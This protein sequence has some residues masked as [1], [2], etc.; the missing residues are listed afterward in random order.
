MS[1]FILTDKVLEEEINDL[2][3]NGMPEGLYLN[4]NSLDEMFRLDLGMVAIYTGVP[5]YGKSEFIDFVN[6]RLNRLYGLKVLY[7][8]PEN[9]PVKL[10]LSK[11][12]SKITHKKFAD[13][14]IEEIN[15]AM[16]IIKNNFFFIN[17]ENSMSIDDILTTA[18]Y[19]ISNLGIKI[20]TIDPYNRI[21]WQRPNNL[22]ETEYVGVVMDKLSRFAKKHNILVQLV[23]HPK[24]MQTVN[25]EVQIPNLY[26]LNGSANFANMADYVIIV[27]RDFLN[28]YTTIKVDK[29]KFKN[30]GRIGETYIRY[31]YSDGNYQEIEIDG[32]DNE[33]YKVAKNIADKIL[34]KREEIKAKEI[35]S[36][37]VLDVDISYFN[38]CFEMEGKT[39][40]L[41][42][43]LTDPDNEYYNA[44]WFKVEEIR[45]A[46]SK[47]DIRELKNKSNLPCVTISCVT[48]KDKTDIK[49]VNNLIAID[50]D[51]QD[52]EREMIDI[53]EQLKML[54]YVA[55][56]AKS[57]SG[58]GLFCII[59]ILDAFSIKDYFNA[60]KKEF[61]EM[62][63][64]IDKN[65]SNVNRL[66]FYSFDEN[67]YINPNAEIYTKKI[68]RQI[69]ITKTFEGIKGKNKAE[70]TIIKIINILQKNKDEIKQNYKLDITYDY[71][72]WFRIGA[73]IANTFGENGYKYFNAISELSVK[74]NKYECRYKYTE[75]LC[76]PASEIQFGTLVKL[77]TD[78]F[79]FE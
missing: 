9:M 19:A 30:Y 38:N 79:R 75:L 55:Y 12:I 41:Y 46:E 67:Y 54:K 16:E 43:Y 60:I 77:F 76:N 32:I 70:N 52:N 53:F 8:S 4:F 21:E 42:N 48:G 68:D 1:E 72:N 25:L 45:K 71:N 18:E 34:Q 5:N 44:N 49:A 3:Q 11:L 14:N 51:K 13:L 59:P 69:N 63:I 58:Q 7:F 37:N 31:N 24:K 61:E 29:V 56:A 10:H 15:G 40:N 50:I 74:Y 20:L 57:V 78:K 22:S 66:R 2:V 36:K 65:C 33:K 6:V 26:D 47:E 35:K 27:H 23:V 39:I 62:G 17:T 64:I 73:A 28:N